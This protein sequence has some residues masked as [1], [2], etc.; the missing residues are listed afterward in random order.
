MA[1]RLPRK[2]A[3]ILYADVAGYSRLTGE[4]EDGTH[5]TLRTYLDLIASSIESHDGRVVHYAGD[6]VLADFSTV[7]DALSC[8]AAIQG[9]LKQRNSDVPDDRKV[10][11]RIGVN[12]GDVII[13][14]EEIYGDG[15]NV[16]ARL[17]ALADP[18]GICISDSVRT[19]V[20]NKLNLDY[21]NLGKQE[22]KNISEPVEAYRVVMKAEEKAT[23]TPPESPALELPEEPSIAVLPFQNMSG[24][25]EQEYFSDGI[26]EDIIT[27]LS[28]I[29]GLLVV[30]RNSTMVYKGKAV[31]VKQVG[32]EQGVRYVLEGSVRKAGSRVRVTAQLIDATTGHHKWAERYD[33]ELEDIFSVQDDITH[34]II[35]EMR[36][37]ISEG[38]KA[39]M[40]AGRTSNFKAWECLLHADDLNNANNRE[41]NS[42]ALR[43]AEKAVRL[44]P[45]YASAW[46]ELGW[47]HWADIFFG[48]SPSP[49]QS[50]TKAMDA[51]QRALE[52]EEN[53][54]NALSLLGWLAVYR[55]EHDDAVK[56]TEQA[57]ILETQ[58]LRE[59]RRIRQR[60][61]VCRKDRGSNYHS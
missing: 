42:E 39:R 7:V 14:Q 19:A 34:Q 58:Q 49:E 1:D 5:R 35:V 46:T 4:D 41:D 15:V 30:A 6:A 25:P 55:G 36:V 24:D 51:A 38:E 10:Q 21:E 20:G 43:F 2:L 45:N 54:P 11:F 44:D 16:A 53:Y 27:A 59:R 9:D 8:A 22:V 60:P 52:L 61:V 12:L 47:V 33:R 48:W 18:A 29:S 32:K 26:T 37:R 17:E 23:T 57:V 3:A 56:L 50:E 40:L 13:D 31:D 28:R